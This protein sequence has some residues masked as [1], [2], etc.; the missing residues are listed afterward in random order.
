M[1]GRI[2]LSLKLAVT[3]WMVVCVPAYAV[4]YGAANFL[5]VSDVALFLTFVAVWTES[6]HLASSQL[7]GVVLINL[8]WTIDVGVALLTGVHPIGG[9]EYMFDG[10]WPLYLR[11]MSL[12][13]LWVPLVLAFMVVRIGYTG[14]GVA[15]QTAIIWI[16]L[17]ATYLLTPAEHN[18]NWVH[19]PFGQHQEVVA[20]GLYL[21]ITMAVYPLVFLL[22][23]LVVRG[24]QRLARSA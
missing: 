23:H 21:L 18:V 14:R 6:R 22:G 12:F 8:A 1:R 10:E 7:V 11:L 5:W 3:A 15:L 24:V 13:H 9:T 16:L 19:G 4:H 20:P 2:S 17:P